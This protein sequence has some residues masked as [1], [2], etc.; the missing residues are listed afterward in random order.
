MLQERAGNVCR[1]RFDEEEA[2]PV[3]VNLL[4]GILRGGRQT[5]F[6]KGNARS[7]APAPLHSP[8]QRESLDAHIHTGWQSAIHTSNELK[9]VEASMASNRHW[10]RTPVMRHSAERAHNAKPAMRHSA[11][12]IHMSTGMTHEAQ[13]CTRRHATFECPISLR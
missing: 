13:K 3:K 7:T 9:G 8:C 4:E 6:C 2:Q 10:F 1:V 11:R 12:R 5:E